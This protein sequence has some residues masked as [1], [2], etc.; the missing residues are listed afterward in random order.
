MIPDLSWPM[1][2]ALCALLAILS[3]AGWTAAACLLIGMKKRPSRHER[4]VQRDLANAARWDASRG[5]RVERI[6][7]KP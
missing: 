7:R 4:A 6:L 2:G 5:L 1:L 3:A